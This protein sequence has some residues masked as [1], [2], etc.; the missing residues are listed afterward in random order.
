MSAGVLVLEPSESEFS[1]IMC[2]LDRFMRMPASKSQF[3]EQ[4][5]AA[6]GGRGAGFSMWATTVWEDTWVRGP[7]GCNTIP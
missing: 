4:E 3:F 7:E 1:A 2:T 6:R 5:P